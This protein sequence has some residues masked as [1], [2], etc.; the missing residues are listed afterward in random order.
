MTTTV[1]V[2]LFVQGGFAGDGASAT[3]LDA[4]NLAPS[5][6]RP[7][8]TD[9]L[10]H[11]MFARTLD[12]LRLSLGVGALAARIATV[13][14]VILTVIAAT[15]RVGDMIVSWL[16]DLFLALPHLVLIILIAFVL[17]G[18]LR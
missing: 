3:D 5:I 4:R 7:F 14:A 9:P 1:L 18:G 2:L 16:T 11:D 13:L 12:G 15:G 10:G 6:T 17:G 8:G